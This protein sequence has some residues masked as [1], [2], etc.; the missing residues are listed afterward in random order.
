MEAND[1]S[2]ILMGKKLFGLVGGDM[3]LTERKC[4]P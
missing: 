4:N 2:A 3:R 1:A